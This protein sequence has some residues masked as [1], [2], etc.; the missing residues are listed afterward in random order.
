MPRFSCSFSW[1]G[2]RLHPG[3]LAV[4]LS[5]SPDIQSRKLHRGIDIP[6]PRRY[7]HQSGTGW[8]GLLSNYNN[9][10]E[11]CDHRMQRKRNPLCPSVQDVRSP[12]HDGYPEDRPSATSEQP[13]SST[14]NHLHFEVWTNSA[15][16]SLRQSNELFL[17]RHLIRDSILAPCRFQFVFGQ[18]IKVKHIVLIVFTFKERWYE[19]QGPVVSLSLRSISS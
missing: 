1:P 11:L 4:W 5:H 3:K 6:A 13:A 14:G 19:T 9:S 12:P 18:A 8:R 10:Y 16:S 17:S 7:P 15:S 2:A